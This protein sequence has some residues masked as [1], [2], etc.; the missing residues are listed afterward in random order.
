MLSVIAVALI[1]GLL[2]WAINEIRQE[3][4]KLDEDE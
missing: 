2:L 1:I 3:D 4:K